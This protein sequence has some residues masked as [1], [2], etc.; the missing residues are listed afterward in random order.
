MARKRKLRKHT[1]RASV[2]NIDLTK[3]GTSIHLEVF[4]K[5]EKIGTVELG[6]GTIRWYGRHKHKA[7]R[8]SWTKFAEW[9][10]GL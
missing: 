4:A 8:I 10:D 1:A 5:D 9:M 6:R 7:T 3:T 2:N